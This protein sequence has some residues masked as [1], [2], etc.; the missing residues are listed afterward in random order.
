MTAPV[1]LEKLIEAEA[2]DLAN[3]PQLAAQRL[4]LATPELAFHLVAAF[5]AHPHVCNV[6]THVSRADWRAVERALNVILDPATTSEGLS[7]LARNLVE[8][9]C[10]ERGVT[11][12]ILKPCFHGVLDRLLAPD[13]S[14]RL[15][16]RVEALYLGLEWR[17]QPPAPA[18]ANAGVDRA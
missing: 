1:R 4:Q 13:R 16:A 10:A 3:P 5:R 12:R 14:E 6:L 17:A 9:M 2:W 8:L 15:I 7:P 11:G 18:P